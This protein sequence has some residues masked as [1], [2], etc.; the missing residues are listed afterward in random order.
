MNPYYESFDKLLQEEKKQEA[1]ALALDLLSTGKIDPVTLYS[2]ILTPVLNNM[3]CFLAEKQL[4][5]WKEHVRTAAVRT[6]V[7]CCYPFVIKERDRLA[8]PHMGTAVVICP[9]EEYHD[10]GARMAADF[11][12]LC[13]FDTIFVGS[14]TPFQDFSAAADLIRPDIIAIGVS[15]YYNLVIT[16]KIITELRHR[17][18]SNCKIIVGG[19]AFSDSPENL[20]AVGADDVAQTFEDVK[21]IAATFTTE[22]RDPA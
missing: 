8:P 20:A 5:V 10:L 16:R 11:F 13:G 2:E 7:E 18:G 9:P 21:R 12:T 14:N 19:N 17:I 3:Q 1:V 4:C 22:G 15:N 6:I